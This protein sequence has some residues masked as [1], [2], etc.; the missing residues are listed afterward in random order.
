MPRYLLASCCGF[1]LPAALAGCLLAK[2]PATADGTASRSA[3]KPTVDL[4]ARWELFVDDWLIAAAR[5]PRSSCTH[6]S[7]ARWCW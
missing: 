5:M 1:V 4:G 7:A 2:A 3:S 6:P